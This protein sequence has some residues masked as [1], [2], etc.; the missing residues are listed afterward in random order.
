[1]GETSNAAVQSLG[2]PGQA[3]SASYHDSVFEQFSDD[4]AA[5]LI[6]EYPLAWVRPEGSGGEDASLLPL[7]AARGEAG[8][9][10]HLI[11]HLARSNPLAQRLVA[12]P[13][14]LILFQGP[15]AYVSPAIVGRRNWAPTWNFAQLRIAGEV[16]FQ[17]AADDAL[18][19]LVDTMEA[20]QGN[21][22]RVEETGP[23]YRAMER[24]IAAF[25]VEVL[26]ISGRFKLGQ[27]EKPEDLGAIIANH[28]DSALV[29]WM[30]RFN[31]GRY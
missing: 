20:P 25:H 29:R 23:R 30:K 8:R 6:A 15:Q 27:D 28:S 14:A 26:T 3:H 19:L 21:P 31:Q 4:D 2:A 16:V 5:A 7:L 18:A 11:G 10:T 12:E 22:W 1:M 17:A 13:K 9:I 24:S